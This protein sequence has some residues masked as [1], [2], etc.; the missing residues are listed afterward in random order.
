MLSGTKTTFSEMHRER[1]EEE[2]EGPNDIRDVY[3]S[4]WTTS[5]DGKTV[6]PPI[7]L[8]NQLVIRLKV[9]FILMT[10]TNDATLITLTIFWHT[11]HFLFSFHFFHTLI[12]RSVCVRLQAKHIIF[13]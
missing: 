9:D 11:N 10:R 6:L 12:D 8:S 5:V 4:F 7:L 13:M 3:I 1:N 2:R